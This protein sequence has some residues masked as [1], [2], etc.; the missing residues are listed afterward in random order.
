MAKI[1][2]NALHLLVILDISI[3]K[4]INVNIYS[5]TFQSNVTQ[6]NTKDMMVNNG[7]IFNLIGI[8]I[9]TVSNEYL[10]NIY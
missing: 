4:R 8:V 10:N 6:W 7:S 9:F 2:L 3:H 5:P 1:M